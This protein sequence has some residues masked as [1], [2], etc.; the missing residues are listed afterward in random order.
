MRIRTK[1]M[2]IRVV[3]HTGRAFGA[4][5]GLFLGA[6][7]GASL[8]GSFWG[9]LEMPVCLQKK[10]AIRDLVRFRYSFGPVGGFPWEGLLGLFWASS[11]GF[12]LGPLWGALFGGPGNSWMTSIYRQ[13]KPFC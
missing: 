4:I 9:V 6:L 5:L 13:Y 11:W 1:V 7:L 10:A 8:G 3:N 12:F 2:S